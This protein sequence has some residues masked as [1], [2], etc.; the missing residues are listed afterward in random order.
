MKTPSDIRAYFGKTCF[1]HPEAATI[2]SDKEERLPIR[3]APAEK[4]AEY[5]T[6]NYY[7]EMVEN[8]QCADS[9]GAWCDESLVPVAAVVP[10]GSRF[11]KGQKQFENA[12]AYLFWDHSE[13]KLVWATTDEW[14]RS[15]NI[16]SIDDLML[17]V[18]EEL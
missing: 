6:E 4:L 15:N 7:E 8:L 9:D 14:D 3:F 10:S 11:G 12:F 16:D 5:L 13:K 18:D 2:F 1:V 17:E